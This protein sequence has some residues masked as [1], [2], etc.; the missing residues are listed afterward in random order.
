MASINSIQVKNLKKFKGHEG[1]PLYQGNIYYKGKKLGFWSQ[2]AWGAICDNYGFNENILKDEVE[3][4]KASDFVEDEYRK[5]TSLESL[6][7]DL[8]TLTEQEKMFKQYAKKG[9]PSTVVITDGYHEFYGACK[10]TKKEDVL[11]S[12]DSY[13]KECKEKCYKN[14]K[15]KVIVY[16]DLKD[17]DVTI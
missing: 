16:M 3:K 14:K 17:F 2:D 15:S 5:Y 1:E 12:F 4:Y 9:Y 10:H 11:K 7:S 6:L 13:I 8:I